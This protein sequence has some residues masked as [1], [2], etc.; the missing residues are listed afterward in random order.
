MIYFR[1]PMKPLSGTGPILRAITIKD[2]A[3]NG[4]TNKAIFFSIKPITD[5]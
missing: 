4:I 3:D 5:T 2:R 1:K